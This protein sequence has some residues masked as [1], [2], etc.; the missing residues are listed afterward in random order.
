MAV[1]V[2]HQT[3]SLGGP[4]SS[5]QRDG[6]L[7]FWLH[8]PHDQLGSFMEQ[9][10]G[11]LTRQLVQELTPQ[12]EFTPQQV[13]LRNAVGAKLHQE[14]LNQPIAGQ[15]ILANFLLSPP[16]LLTINNIDQFFDP[17]LC[18]AYK[19]LYEN[20]PTSQPSPV[21]HVTNASA[22]SDIPPAPD[23]G[24][25]PS[26]LHELVSNR[27]H[28][29]RLL[30]LSNLYYID[31]EDREI[32]SELIELRRNL[33]DAIDCCP[34][35]ELEQFWSTEFGERYWVLVRS[36]IQRNS[37]RMMKLESKKQ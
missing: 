25:F 27:L 8:A 37:R 13:E 2:P 34:E 7:Q 23:F 11:T 10:L 24:P 28:L 3:W 31:P 12:H 15:L 5:A 20:V 6:L 33:V 36:G 4:T 16:G 22:A 1:P 21:E 19:E 18:S 32:A 26:T 17:W 29:N 30:G 35:T 9:C 14:G